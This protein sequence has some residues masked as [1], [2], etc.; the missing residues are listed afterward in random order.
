M[1]HE[2]HSMCSIP[3]NLR[4]KIK[5]GFDV[6]AIYWDSNNIFFKYFP[7]ESFDVNLYQRPSTPSGIELYS[8]NRRIFLIDYGD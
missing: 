2:M 6:K 7:E 4:K 3:V 5:I 8:F 1:K